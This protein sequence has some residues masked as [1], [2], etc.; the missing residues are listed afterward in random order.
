MK[1]KVRNKLILIIMSFQ[2]LK[3]QLDSTIAEV[4]AI[5]EHLEKQKSSPSS[6]SGSVERRQ[7]LSETTPPSAAPK[8]TL[9]RVSSGGDS[10]TP[11]PQP[12]PTPRTIKS[13]DSKSKQSPP[14]SQPQP[15]KEDTTNRVFLRQSS[16]ASR[17]Q[18]GDDDDNVTRRTSTSS[19]GANTPSNG[20]IF[21][22]N[23][24]L[25]ERRTSQ[26]NPVQ[27]DDGAVGQDDN[28]NA[29][30]GGFRSNRDF[31]EQRV[32]MRQKQTPD[33]VLDL[34]VSTLSTSPGAPAITMTTDASPTGA[35][36][37][38]VVPIPK[39]RPRPSVDNAR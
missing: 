22:K 27:V 9:R 16:W 33:L 2:E 19:L 12:R 36:P 10:A 30:R 15:P 26:Q 1:S 5:A 23:R 8:P 21:A 18:I 11:Q 37:A 31:W 17:E 38:M 29:V 13:D 24:S 35:T 4:E 3:T 6:E 7:K 20:G 32:T 14:P 28:G 39:P 25:W 34:P